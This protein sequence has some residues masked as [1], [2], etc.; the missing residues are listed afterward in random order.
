[1]VN[2]QSKHVKYVKNTGK[3][4]IEGI[5]KFALTKTLESIWEKHYHQTVDCIE[6]IIFLCGSPGSGKTSICNYTQKYY[7]LDKLENDKYLLD[8]SKMCGDVMKENNRK[9]ILPKFMK[10]YLKQY[11]KIIM[12]IKY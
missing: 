12:K 6:K 10:N 11:Y 5:S 4:D 3:F 2:E 7:K 8:T 9:L 1:M